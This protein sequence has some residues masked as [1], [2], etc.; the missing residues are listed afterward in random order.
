MSKAA[1][2]HNPNNK[3]KE[4]IEKCPV[5]GCGKSQAKL[6]FCSEHFV[7]FKE[8]LINKRGEKPRDFDKKY[9]NYL[10]KQAA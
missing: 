4:F 6:N 2:N 8:G 7:W 9:Q 5:D 1:K 3:V 10:R